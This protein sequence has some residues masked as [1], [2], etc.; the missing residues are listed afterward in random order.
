M[1]FS[2]VILKNFI[3]PSLRVGNYRWKR[4]KLCNKVSN[5]PN[6]S[7]LICKQLVRKCNSGYLTKKEL[8]FCKRVSKDKANLN[9]LQDLEDILSYLLK[10]Y[11]NT[12]IA[13]VVDNEEE[14]KIFLLGKYPYVTVPR[15]FSYQWLFI[16]SFSVYPEILTTYPLAAKFPPL[17]NYLNHL[18]NKKNKNGIRKILLPPISINKLYYHSA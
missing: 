4:V 16:I 5:Y 10:S 11:S 14:E 12:E 18:L 6:S 7:Y 2:I 8:A 3:L 1:Q 9:S 15:K 13:V 17:N